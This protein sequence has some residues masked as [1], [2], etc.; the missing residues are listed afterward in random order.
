MKITEFKHEKMCRPQSPAYISMFDFIELYMKE[1]TTFI[2]KI[3]KKKN[4]NQNDSNKSYA[5][6]MCR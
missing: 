1:F 6:F 3:R 4:T 2:F 5:D